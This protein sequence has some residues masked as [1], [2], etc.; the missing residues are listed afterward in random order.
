M[1]L[2]AIEVTDATVSMADAVG[3]SGVNLPRRLNDLDIKGS[4]K[5][6]PVHY[7]IDLEHLSFRGDGPDLS[8]GQAAGRIGVRDDNVY[9]EQ[10][11]IATAESSLKV[12]GVIEQYL[13]TPVMKLTIS[14]HASL[15]EIGRVIPALAEYKLHPDFEVKANGPAERVALD[16]NVRSEAGNIT[17]Q[18]TADL[19]GPAMGARGKVNV[20]RLNL[21][22]I[23]RDPSQRSDITGQAQ[24]DLN[25]GATPAAAN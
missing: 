5:Y 13:K 10:M 22:P 6:A 14:G 12:D 25:V 19:Q 20:E 2:S 11:S 4:F 16:L 9:I 1:S 24:L 23:L 18:L 3:T 15:P 8:I 7:S 17:G 21:A